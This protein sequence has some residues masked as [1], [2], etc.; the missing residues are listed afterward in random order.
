MNRERVSLFD[1]I[2]EDLRLKE[3]NVA[4]FAEQIHVSLDY[5]NINQTINVVEDRFKAV[6][7]LKHWFRSRQE[8]RETSPSHIQKMVERHYWLFGEEL[9]LVAAEE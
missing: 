8:I 3:R 9:H 7:D 1:I 6:E 5:P 4:D 2:R